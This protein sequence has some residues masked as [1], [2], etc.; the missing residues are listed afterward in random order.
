MLTTFKIKPPFF[1]IGPKVYMWGDKLLELALA[2][3]SAAQRLDVDVIITPP[4]TDITTIA[5]AVKRIHVFAQHTDPVTAG[6]GQGAVL[7]EALKDAGAVGVMLNHAERKLGRE[8]LAE[9]VRRAE[10][11]GLAVMACA[12][13]PDELRFV[14]SLSP[15]IIAA[16]PTA[17]IGTGVRSDTDYIHA[18][19]SAVK[20]VNPDIM[21]LQ[22]AGISSAADV[23]A[24][25]AAGA[26]ATGSSSAIMNSDDPPATAWEMLT[27]LRLAWDERQTQQTGG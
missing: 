9:S 7:P 4:Y 13:S 6:K 8:Q 26:Q 10:E 25:I 21:V 15:N 24:V 12:D 2:A 19:I 11:A 20:S 5:R 1:E 18:A 16:E 14:A 17:L 27:A 22:G 3:D 23:S